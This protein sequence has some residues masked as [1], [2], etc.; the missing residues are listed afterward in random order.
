MAKIISFF[1]Q[2]GGVGKTTSAVNLAASF[3]SLG[4]KVLLVDFDPQANATSSLGVDKKSQPNIYHTIIEEIHP[5]DSIKKTF[6]FSLDLIPAHPD[7]AGAIIELVSLENRE[8]K[9]KSAIEKISHLYDYILI[10]LP[11]SLTL[12]SINGLLASQEVIVPIQC[13]YLAL[14]GL[15]QLLETINLIKTNINYDLKIKG[16]LLTM[17]EK[18]EKLSQEILKN[19]WQNFP[20][21]LFKTIIPRSSVAA[22][23]PSFGRPVL[24]YKPEDPISKAYINLAKEIIDLDKN[25]KDNIFEKD[26]GNFVK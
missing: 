13:E 10:D 8:F 24:F 4:K 12:L 15:A 11:P 16:G 6:I 5:K 7:L 21:N 19:V 3:S 20:E 1:N 22:L 25:N 18:K 14:E 26:F 17:Y 23:A 9:L 2:K